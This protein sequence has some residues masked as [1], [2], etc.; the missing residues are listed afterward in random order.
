MRDGLQPFCRE[1]QRAAVKDHYNRNRQY[2]LD[3]ATRQRLVRVHVTIELIRRLKSVPCAGCGLGYPYFVM[4]FD[5]VEGP[6]LFNVGQRANSTVER[7]LEEIAKCEVVCANCH[8]DRTYRR[9]LQARQDG[10]A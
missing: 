7:L 10:A 5:H 8:A 1:C 3:K 9:M 2:Y 4:A 6:K